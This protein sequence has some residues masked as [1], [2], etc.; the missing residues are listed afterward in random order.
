[1]AEAD[2]VDREPIYSDLIRMAS[3][4]LRLLRAFDPWPRRPFKF[5]QRHYPFILLP[6]VRVLGSLLLKGHH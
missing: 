3:S 5:Q 2:T 4:P 1:M 6:T